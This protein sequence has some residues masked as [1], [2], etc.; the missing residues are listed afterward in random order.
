MIYIFV[1]KDYNNIHQES[2]LSSVKK[3]WLCYC[4]CPS[5]PF[6]Y[7]GI[8][9]ATQLAPSAFMVSVAGCSELVHQILPPQL[10]IIPNLHMS[11]L[12][13]L[14]SRVAGDD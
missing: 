5:F 4:L 8:Y 14:G 7:S 11:W 6:R 12:I 3:S 2:H 9:R 13:Q 10:H 1:Y